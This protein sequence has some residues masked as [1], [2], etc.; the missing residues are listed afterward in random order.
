MSLAIGRSH[1]CLLAV[2]LVMGSAFLAFGQ[3]THGIS[4]SQVAKQPQLVVQVGHTR[5]ISGIA[6]SPD[7]HFALTGSNDKTAILWDTTTGLEIRAFQGHAK[8]ILGVAFFPDGKS[9]LT[10]SLDGTARLWDVI[11]GREK[12]LFRPDGNEGISSVALSPDGRSVLVGHLNGGVQLLDIEN[13]SVIRTFKGHR[14]NVTSL[15]FSKNGNR[16]LTASWDNSVRL[17]DRE[18]GKQ[19]RNFQD[20]DAAFESVDFSPD[21]RWILAASEGCKAD[22]WDTTAGEK[23][24]SFSQCSNENKGASMRASFSPDGRW[25]LLGDETPTITL[26]NAETG[27]LIRTF[28]SEDRGVSRFTFSPDGSWIL[29][30]RFDGTACLWDAR[31]GQEIRTFSA[32]AEGVHRAAVSR[33][34]KRILTLNNFGDDINLW[35]AI[36][37]LWD[38]EEGHPTLTIQLGD[39]IATSVAMS[40]DGRRILTGSDHEKAILRDGTTGQPISALQGQYHGPMTSLS[41]L[42]FEVTAVAF[43]PDGKF[44]LTGGDDWIARLWDPDTGV[45]I[46]TFPANINTVASVS[47]APDIKRVLTVSGDSKFD[48]WDINTGQDIRRFDTLPDGITS[49]AISPDGHQILT[50]FDSGPYSPWA[51][52]WDA[53][54][55]QKIRNLPSEVEGFG[56]TNTTSTTTVAFSADGHRI[57]LGGSD[58]KVRLWDSDNSQL[59]QTLAGH[60][61]SVTVAQFV[62][63]SQIILTSSSDGT[64]RFW[65]STTGRELC[66]LVSFKSGGWA[67]VDPDGRFDTSDLD[68]NTALHWV[69]PDDPMRPVPIEI[70]MHDYYTPRLL[71]RIMNGEPLPP[72]RSIA[73]IKNRVQPSVEILRAEPSKEKPGRSD[74]TVRVASVRDEKGTVSGLADLK[75]F[76]DGQLVGFRKDALRDG[77]YIF[78]GIQLPSTTRKVVFTAYAFN[79]ERIE[80]ATVSKDYEYAPTQIAKPR[81]WLVQ[82]GENHYAAQ[83]CEL[84]GSANDAEGL[85][86]I[87]SEK[88][89]ARGFD[90]HP[91]VLT[92]TDKADHARRA[93]IRQAL[94]AIASQATPDDAFFLSFSGHGYGDANGTYYI[95]P[96]D[97][98][99]S[100]AA[101]DKSLLDEAVSADEL[102]EW[103]RPI[104]AGEMTFILDACD[105]AASVDVGGFKPGP[106]GSRGLGQLAYDKRMRVLAASQPNQPAR[107]SDQLGKGLLTWAL[108]DEGLKAGK[109]DWKPV[110]NKITL[111]EWLGYAAQAVPKYLEAGAV[112][113]SRGLI[114][115]GTP[116]TQVPSAQTPSVFDFSKGDKFTLQ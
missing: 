101:V 107:E 70:F 23:V 71:S 85:S 115:I 112:K 108:T 94:A 111:G 44:V 114:L 55:G 74:V 42:G 31:T 9:V 50:G 77:E 59:L 88:L 72:I 90:V 33:D 67:V 93:D 28:Q 57:V 45:E 61:G 21:D 87:L 65:D 8:A 15:A 91:L 100:C 83:G 25:I 81:A 58:N 64:S 75:L 110:D 12:R 106:M 20:K 41:V 35:N 17:W 40:A 47:F 27:K 43:S 34:G 76:R 97:V 22:L 98:Q 56:L 13:G 48:L 63:S 14:E 113:G 69:L 29:T 95:L 102:A 82:I 36:I 96:S 5:S 38:V 1:I 18:T 84:H 7:G 73:E 86:A 60:A 99:G 53:R 6:F 54:T 37:N 46:R 3:A 79:S 24:R 2:P 19:I 39:E 78:S 4:A 66:E 92:S 80:S 105:S 89:K 30:G 68:E 32:N 26:L 10:G 103:L 16:I 49:I 104:D 51:T 52:L 62:P 11:T 116:G 109:A